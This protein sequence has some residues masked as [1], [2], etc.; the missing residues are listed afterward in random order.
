M[1]TGGLLAT[2]AGEAT[3]LEPSAS[4]IMIDKSRTVSPTLP[5]QSHVP[6]LGNDTPILPTSSNETPVADGQGSTPKGSLPTT[7]I[8]IASLAPNSSIVAVN[9]N[10]TTLEK[11]LAHSTPS[12]GLFRPQSSVFSGFAAGK[13][14]AP[15]LMC[16]LGVIVAVGILG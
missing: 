1:T 4:A 2:I 14:A 5:Y 11:P 6:V 15:L 8:Q 13:T 16:A 7:R 12:S 3:F 9:G 10:I